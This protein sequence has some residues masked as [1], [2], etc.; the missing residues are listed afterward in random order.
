MQLQKQITD[1][2]RRLITLH[3]PIVWNILFSQRNK[4]RD[5]IALIMFI[6]C[7]KITAEKGHDTRDIAEVTLQCA[8]ATLERNKMISKR[9][10]VVKNA[11]EWPRGTVLLGDDHLGLTLAT[12]WC[13]IAIAEGLSYSDWNLE[14]RNSAT[15]GRLR[16]LSG[17][18]FAWK[19]NIPLVAQCFKIANS[20]FEF[21]TFMLTML[22]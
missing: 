8:G 20:W 12:P 16:T 18:I 19:K 17:R 22:L 13:R 10:K 14:A 21:F 2:K 6:Y 7:F 9:A 1:E 4:W 5:L 15:V 3:C 11:T